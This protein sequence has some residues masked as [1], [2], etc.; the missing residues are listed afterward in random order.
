MNS[1]TLTNASPA[2]SNTRATNLIA[3]HP[4][5]AVLVI[6]FA[7]AWSVWIPAALGSQGLIPFQVPQVLGVLIGWAP[8]IAA[9]VVTGI[10]EGRKGIV[11]L[12]KRFLI[13]RVGLAW[14][15]V[16]LFGI[17]AAILGGIGL[18]VLFGGTMPKIPVANVP[19]PTAVL[20]F[21][22]TVGFGFLV[23]TEE[24]AW[25]GFML[26][27]LQMRHS[28]LVASVLIAIPEMLLHLPSFFD[29][30]A[31]FYQTVGIGTFSVFTFALAILYTWLFNNTR[32]SLLLVTLAHASQ[33]AW[34]NLLSDNSAAPFYG[35]VALLWLAV[36]IV[37]FVFG[38]R[39][40]SRQAVASET[41]LRNEQ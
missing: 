12:L 27:R 18:Y 8:A 14:Y 22:I 6:M 10:T 2:A 37:I 17:A 4:I 9:I 36:V 32:G 15:A 3:R 19:L 39:R 1:V 21:L 28:A 13:V 23:N 24:V 11:A 35:T 16:A 40:L 41:G 38:A 34:A 5:A 26:P 20:V 29:K 33:N 31:V 7:L 30:D 25:R